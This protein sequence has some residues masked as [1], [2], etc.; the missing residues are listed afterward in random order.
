[1]LPLKMEAVRFRTQPSGWGW[2]VVSKHTSQSTFCPLQEFRAASLKEEKSE[3]KDLPAS[4]GVG[5]GWG[6]VEAIPHSISA[7]SPPPHPSV[8]VRFFFS[9]HVFISVGRFPKT[10]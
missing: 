5:L 3:E 7:L 6:C 1:M 4:S 9:L 8:R 2:G 10:E